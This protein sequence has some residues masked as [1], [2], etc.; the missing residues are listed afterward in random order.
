MIG[1]E[2]NPCF[3]FELLGMCKYD[4]QSP[5]SSYFTIGGAVTALTL[6]L[7]VQQFL[8]PIYQFR[9]RVMG[10]SFSFVICAV[11][12]GAF[13][14]IIAAAVPSVSFLRGTPFGYPVNWEILG[15]MIIGISYAYVVW[16]ALRP[17]AVTKRNIGAFARAGTLLLSE[18]TDEDRSSFAKD[19]LNGRNLDALVELTCEF[20]RAESHA[21]KIEFEKLREQN[22]ANE[23][24]RGRLPISPFYAFARRRELEQARDAW[25]LLEL[26]SEREFC[27]VVIARHSLVFLRAIISLAENNKYSDAVRTF[28]QSIAWQALIQEDGMLAKEDRYEGFGWSRMFATNFFGNYKMRIYR[29][30]NGIQSIGICVPSDG[31]VSRLNIASELMVSAELKHRGFWDNNSTRSAVN[32][33]ENVFHKVNFSRSEGKHLTYLFKLSTGVSQLIKLMT[34]ELENCETEDYNLL[35]TS[36]PEKYRSDTIGSITKLVCKGLNSISNDFQDYDDPAWFFAR[37]VFNS[38]FE[39]FDDPP[40]GLSPLQQAVVLKLVEK[41]QENMNGYYPTLCRVLLAII[42]PYNTNVPETPGS[43]IAILK[44]A[45]YLELKRLP[46]LYDKAPDKVAERLPQNVT[47]DHTDHSLTH[48]Y[49][50]GDKVKTVLDELQLERVDL[51]A[52]ENLRYR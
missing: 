42:G 29:P 6:T 22:K 40:K 9:L 48:T 37:E 27:R 45:I 47:Y 51:L 19:V 13:C 24:V 32:I 36:D 34:E 25:H 20:S 3:G 39:R 17:A 33:Y 7:A 21:L 52:K 26:M 28:V 4:P 50:G 14:T 11:F 2:L 30:L 12:M 43:A 44:D 31:F 49:R 5:S 38:V 8:K 15:G 41:V 16:I 18:A 35:F 1:N 10:V 46:E 23:G